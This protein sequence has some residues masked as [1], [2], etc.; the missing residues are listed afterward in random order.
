MIVPTRH[1]VLVALLTIVPI[2][3]WAIAYRPMNIAVHAAADEIRTR[4]NRLENMG[5][6]NTQ[7]RKIKEMTKNL[8]DSVNE[9][10]ARIPP[11]PD[12]E[13]WLHSASDAAQVLGLIVRSV[14]T[15]GQREDGDFRILPVDMSV[16]GSF[17]NVYN[18]I[19]HFERMNRLSRIERMTIH[20]VDD[21]QVDA[22]LI[23]HLIF[24]A[25]SDS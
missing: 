22:R 15:S 17:S 2:S 20:R 6:I 24:Q 19:Q 8:T 23:I 13:Q 18:L 5:V 7:Y 25:E 12:A 10:S 14:T 3:T 1:L 9:I 16:S 21:D 11:N 4:T